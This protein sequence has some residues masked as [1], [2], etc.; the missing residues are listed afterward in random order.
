VLAGSEPLSPAA[1]RQQLEK[2]ARL[3]ENTQSNL[4]ISDGL[5]KDPARDIKIRSWARLALLL[6]A[7]LLFATAL[8]Y[9]GLLLAQAP[10][11]VEEL[12]LK[13]VLGASVLRIALESMCGPVFTVLAGFAVA[14]YCTITVLWTISRHQLH[15]LWSGG[16]SWKMAAGVLGGGLAIACLLAMVVGLVPTLRLLRDS[17]APQLGYTSTSSRTMNIVLY[18]IVSAQISSC[19]VVC[20]IAAMIVSAV[21]S[22][23]TETLG[24]QADR[25][26]VFAVTPATKNAPFSFST[27]DTTDFPLATF[28]RSVVMNSS[29]VV[30]GAESTAAA[31]CAPL[32]Q[33][34]KTISMQRLDRALPPLT[35]HFCAVSRDFFQVTGNPV[36]E[37]STFSNDS[38]TGEVRELVI[39]RKLANELWPEGNP[40]H[41]SV[42]VEEP[43]WGIQFAGEIVGVAQDMRF[44]GLTNT[45]DATVFLPL[46]GNVFTLAFPLYFLTR[47]ATSL[48]AME[49]YIQRQAVGSTVSLGV[50]SSY[51]VNE[52]LRESFM[53]QEVRVWLSA[54]G[55]ALVAI[56]A[57]LGLYG[58]LV[59]SVNSKKKEMAIRSCF[60]ASTG[61]VRM[62][63]VKQAL[64]CSAVAVLVSLLAWRPMAIMISRAWIG[65]AELSWELLVTIPLLC[66]I[67]AA[68]ISLKP[69][70]EATRVSLSE[71]LRG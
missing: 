24:F 39:N 55:A 59:H 35:V 37:G 42:R 4:R 69:A 17:G 48:H 1:L 33:P 49:G 27:S 10:R 19:I 70:W 45:P 63:V 41:H 30:S 12:R 67:A 14:A 44:S 25:L 5:T 3:P 6:S 65:K 47:D 20:L 31:S 66:L 43:A 57:Y 46:K 68:A 52:R 50:S 53:E 61:N 16:I 2:L 71:L 36:I 11:Y 23:S 13:R 62:L 21:H 15:F 64:Q 32:A 60:G 28:T 22:L 26:T 40:L 38:F 34:L 56:I 7:A 8:N 51:E 29:N 18:S 58:V 9:C 54:G